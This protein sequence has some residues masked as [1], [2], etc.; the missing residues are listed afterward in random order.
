MMERGDKYYMSVC[1]TTGL[2]AIYNPEK[3][4]F[5]SPLADGPVKFVGSLDGK[6]MNIENITKFGRTFSVVCVP[7]SLKLLLQEL[8]TMNIQ[9][10][11]LTEDNIGQLENMT[12]SKNI[13]SLTFQKNPKDIIT[14]IREKLK[15]NPKVEIETPSNEFIVESPPQFPETSP[16]YQPPSLENSPFGSTPSSSPNIRF[17]PLN[18][19]SEASSPITGGV[20]TKFRLDEPYLEEGS[21]P[22]KM[23]EEESNELFE[24]YNV[25]DDVHYRGDLNPN[26]L[27][28]IKNIGDK[29]MTI[30]AETMEDLDPTEN[31]KV[32][33]ASDVYR[34]TPMTY[35]SQMEE[36]DLPETFR[37]PSSTSGSIPKQDFNQPTPYTPIH[38]APNIKIINNGNDFS[39]EEMP[40]TNGQA[41][42]LP[43][44][45]NYSPLEILE[46]L[47]PVR[48]LIEPFENNVAIPS[49]NKNPNE[50][51]F[52]KLRI[53]K[54]NEQKIE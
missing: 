45:N 12:F 42:G 34:P 17:R 47:E 39:M 40:K 19:S 36:P 7:Y 23:K 31:I 20:V 52:T 41:D 8:Q 15:E 16:A 54:K 6:T 51:D 35:T 33:F 9:M 18:Y 14:S 49:M 21:L 29:F 27:W 46:P 22:L 28:R 4:L 13:E 32:V 5:M 3:N 44:Q 2:V 37:I 30:E 10:R 24:Q 26:R 43:I 38:F 50:V 48:P 25:N 53:I 11:L 1:N